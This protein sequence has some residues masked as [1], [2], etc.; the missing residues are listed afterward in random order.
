MNSVQGTHTHIVPIW[1]IWPRALQQQQHTVD[2]ETVQDKQ[3]EKG[4]RKDGDYS[5]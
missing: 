2:Q 5:N 1:L 4:E 3:M